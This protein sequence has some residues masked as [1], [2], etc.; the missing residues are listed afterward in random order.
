LA[1]YYL[2]ASNAARPELAALEGVRI[3][4][5]EETPPGM[6]IDDAFIKSITISGIKNAR[7]LYETQREAE[8][9][10]SIVL[11]T[12]DP[13]FDI[14]EKW[15]R[16]AE[17]ER[18]E[19]IAFLNSIEKERETKRRLSRSR[20]TKRSWWRRSRS[21]CRDTLTGKTLA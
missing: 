3:A 20:T 11:E 1:R 5:S 7:N 13:M 17:L 9:V 15:S 14:A 6:V 2:I 21:L 4:W 10:A 12:N 19:A 18:T 8:L 16:E